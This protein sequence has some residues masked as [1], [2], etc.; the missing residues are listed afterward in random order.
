[1][2]FVNK[3]VSDDRF[4]MNE[5]IQRTVVFPESAL[6]LQKFPRSDWS[7][8]GLGMGITS[9]SCHGGGKNSQIPRRGCTPSEEQIKQSLGGGLKV[10]SLPGPNQ[11]RSSWLFATTV[12]IRTLKKAVYIPVRRRRRRR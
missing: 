2:L 12:S 3:G 9:V 4:K 6:F 8:P 1:M 5:M 10:D 7:L 11:W